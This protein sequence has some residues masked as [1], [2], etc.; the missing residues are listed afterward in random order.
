M[1]TH[2]KYISILLGLFLTSGSISHSQENRSSSLPSKEALS[3]EEAVKVFLALRLV[4]SKGKELSEEKAKRWAMLEIQLLRQHLE[5]ETYNIEYS[6]T[7]GNSEYISYISVLDK[8]IRRT[9]LAERRE[10]QKDPKEFNL[11][12]LTLAMDHLKER[13]QFIE[14]W[15]SARGTN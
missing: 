6:I 3:S 4:V 13:A 10:F 12:Y 5:S 1:K 15:K 8:E 2:F 7:E 11:Y 9:S 14:V